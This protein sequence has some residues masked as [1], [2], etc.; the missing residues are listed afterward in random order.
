MLAFEFPSA[1]PTNAAPPSVD[2]S[3]VTT[4]AVLW[5][6]ASPVVTSTL[7]EWFVAFTTRLPPPATTPPMT[8]PATASPVFTLVVWLMVVRLLPSWTL[9]PL[10][11]FV[12][13]VPTLLLLELDWPVWPLALLVP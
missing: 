10:E 5:P 2:T 11:L 13:C 12:S 9:V 7:S 1:S 4:L 3:P 6:V 8:C